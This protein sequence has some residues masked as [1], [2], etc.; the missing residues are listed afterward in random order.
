[1]RRRQFVGFLGAAAVSLPF[2]A[3]AQRATMP[4][5]GL[6]HGASA[7][8]NAHLVAAFRNG[9]REVGYV[10]GDNVAIEYRWADGQYNRLPAMAVDLINRQV[11][12]IAVM[13]G[14]TPA[15][16]AKA[17]GTSIPIIFGSGADPIK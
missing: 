1:M 7:E 5:I 14:V 9:L 16:A 11:A 4:V 12:V 3:R 17:T 6:L 8:P 13:G 10:E 2:G 15:L